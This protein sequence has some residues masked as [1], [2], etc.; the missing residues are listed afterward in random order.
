MRDPDKPLG[1]QYRSD[2]KWRRTERKAE[3]EERGRKPETT[4]PLK[5]SGGGSI[6]K[7]EWHQ[8]QV[9]GQKGQDRKGPVWFSRKSV[10]REGGRRQKTG[11][12]RWIQLTIVG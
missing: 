8:G 10:C 9:R 6:S 3:A 11:P 1:H 7:R 2:H 4:M 5:P 12:S